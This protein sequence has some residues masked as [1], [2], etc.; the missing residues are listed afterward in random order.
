MRA[1]AK[2][3]RISITTY[4]ASISV[5][6]HAEQWRSADQLLVDA[7]AATLEV[8]VI[9]W[10]AAMSASGKAL[11]WRSAVQRLMQMPSQCLQVNIVAAGATASAAGKRS[12]WK[13]ASLLMHLC[14]AR[15][16]EPNNAALN[17]LTNAS[18]CG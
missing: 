2:A 18:R 14:A 15:E 4:S 10:S 6:G 3:I 13:L 5:C 16:V 12:E 17:T 1:I 7:S 9:A 11:L 8:N